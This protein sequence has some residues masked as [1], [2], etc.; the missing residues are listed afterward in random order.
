MREHKAIQAIAALVTA[1]AVASMI[2]IGHGGFGASL[3]P[4]LPR[5]AGAALARQALSCLKPGGQIM[6]ITRDTD[7]FQNPASDFLLAGFERELRQAH[8]G[9]NT[10][11]RLQTDPLRLVEVPSGDFQ[12]WIHHAAAGDVIVSFMGPP[13]LTP[14]QRRQ[15]GEIQ[16]AV[17][18]FCPGNWPERVDLRP[19]F[20]AGLLRAA[21]VARPNPTRAA[22]NSGQFDQ[23][24]TV[25]TQANVDDFMAAAEK[26][27]GSQSP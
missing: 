2:I 18:A 4:A 11:Q 14:E 17:M 7:A 6:V 3:N 13:L 23:N 1:G 8:A 12:N 20:A 15:L 9:I 21:V 16:P 25:V 27:P 5:A 24:F 26:T 10:L 19:L 22:S